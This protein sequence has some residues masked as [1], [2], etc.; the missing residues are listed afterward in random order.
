MLLPEPGDLRVIRR[1]E[2]THDPK[3]RIRVTGPL[4]RPRRPHSLAVA[5]DQQRQHHLRIERPPTG[6]AQR[7]P[8][9][10]PGQIKLI[11]DIDHQPH[12]MIGRQ[13][14][15]KIN[16]EQELLTPI[17]PTEPLRHPPSI[18]PNHYKQPDQHIP[19]TQQ[20]P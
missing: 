4:D 8:S 18:A 13:P 3:R 16:R 14:L 7:I 20:A 19:K 17:N 2:R 10:Q 6:T 1:I 11:D 12:Q 15:G 9:R 5:V